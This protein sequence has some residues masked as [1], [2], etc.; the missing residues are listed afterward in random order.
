MAEAASGTFLLLHGTYLGGWSWRPVA[1]V[2]RQHGHRVLAPSLDGCGERHG[3]MRPGIDT[4]T[5]AAEIAEL[6][7]FED[8][9]DV[10]VVGTSSGGTVAAKA[11][12]TVPERVNRLVFVDAL[13][14][15]DGQSVRDVVNS[16]PT[17]HMDEVSMGPSA[18]QLRERTFADLAPE[19]REWAVARTTLHPTLT[20]TRPVSLPRFFDMSW[21]ARV[22]WCSG[23]KYPGEEHQRHYA[24]RLG[25]EWIEMK[26]GHYPFLT[27][28]RELAALIV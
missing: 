1:D 8:L 3:A 23:S 14:L 17:A 6:V 10:V 5:Q 4:E 16:P 20:I 12:E 22:I 13:L 21:D 27:A 2:L 7:R 25:A 11:A 26:E 28:P 9:R 15:D 19:L 18:S 24:D